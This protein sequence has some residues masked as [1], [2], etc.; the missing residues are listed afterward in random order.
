[1]GNKL[2]RKC[3]IGLTDYK[4]HFPLTLPAVIDN[5]IEL[6]QLN[7]EASLLGTLTDII[8]VHGDEQKHSSN[9]KADMTDWFMHQKYKEFRELSI[10]AEAVARQMTKDPVSM[11]TFDCWGA[12]Y[13]KGE[14]TKKH[15]H[16]GNLWSWCYYL[17]VPPDAP[18]FRFEDITAMGE[19]EPSSFDVYP[20]ENDLLIFPCWVSLSV[21][22][23][24]S[25]SERMMVAGN[26]QIDHS[27]SQPNLN[28]MM[29]TMV[30]KYI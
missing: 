22:K 30:E 6:R 4:V 5:P 25:N 9:V 16:W 17:E 21:P 11:F 24:V 27:S 1:M 26:I 13:R 10:H 23:S 20:K 12:V 19:S 18:P 7:L 14:Y 15:N 2:T 3:T 8:V 29:Q 28:E